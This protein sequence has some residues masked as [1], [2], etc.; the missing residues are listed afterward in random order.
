MRGCSSFCVTEDTRNTKTSARIQRWFAWGERRLQQ[1][2]TLHL[3]FPLVFN[4]LSTLS[5]WNTGQTRSW[6]HSVTT[7]DSQK[8][9]H[10]PWW[11]SDS[12]ARNAPATWRSSDW[13]EPEHGGGGE[14]QRRRE[15]DGTPSCRHGNNNVSAT[16]NRK[17]HWR[18][19][20]FFT[21]GSSGTNV[22]QLLRPCWTT[23]DAIRPVSRYKY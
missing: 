14:G 11:T 20:R 10:S 3:T 6:F 18:W 16:T 13:L 1:L 21:K 2:H 9:N 12:A 8:N 23:V 22:Q 4:W 5:T 15:A 17:A 7:N 19:A